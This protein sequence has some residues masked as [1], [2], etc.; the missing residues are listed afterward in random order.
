MRQISR[1]T[2]KIYSGKIDK[3]YILSLDKIIDY[4]N[5]WKYKYTSDINRHTQIMIGGYRYVLSRLVMCLW[6][7]IDYLNIKVVARHKCNN[8]PCFNPDHI[9]PGSHSDNILDSV[10][11]N[12]HANASKEVCPKCGSNFKKVIRR[13]R[14]RNITN[15]ERR[16]FNCANE[17]RKARRKL[18]KTN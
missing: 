17:Q 12:T 2:R 3:N 13:D 1:V 10:K 9:E 6:H 8:P 18:G 14:F 16:C 5:C 4:N 7:E 11:S 15:I